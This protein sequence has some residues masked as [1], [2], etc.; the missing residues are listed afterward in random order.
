MIL[1]IAVCIALVIFDQITKYIA[2]ISLK[3]V[4]SVPIIEGVLNLTFVENRGAA[5]GIF[6]GQRWGFV[7]LTLAI[8]AFLIAVYLKLPKTKKYNA[9]RWTIVCL[10]AGALGNF[11]DRLFRGYVVDFIDF[12]LINYPVFNV[13]DIYVVLSCIVWAVLI[14]FVIKD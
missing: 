8:S 11:I 10:E 13:A 9:L 2:L 7:I 12:T 6:Q 14:I 3:P 5:F 4:G 1:P